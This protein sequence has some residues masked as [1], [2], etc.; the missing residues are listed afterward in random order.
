M[1]REPYPYTINLKSRFR[2]RFIVEIFGQNIIYQSL[3][4]AIW[5]IQ[6][7]ISVSAKQPKPF[8]PL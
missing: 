3:I 8:H 1:I 7:C 5:S 2:V 4:L 6:K